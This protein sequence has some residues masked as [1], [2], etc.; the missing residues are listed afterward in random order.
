LRKAKEIAKVA[1]DN[2]S[3]NFKLFSSCE[4]HFIASNYFVN[5]RM[6]GS[7]CRRY[8]PSLGYLKG[9]EEKWEAFGFW[10]PNPTMSTYPDSSASLKDS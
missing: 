1:A 6:T 3:R 9:N 4:I 2:G 5:I 8:L 7:S 10:S